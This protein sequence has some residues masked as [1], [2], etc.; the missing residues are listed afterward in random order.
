LLARREPAPEILNP[1]ANLRKEMQLFLR[2]NQYPR[3]RLSVTCR[4]AVSLGCLSIT[5]NRSSHTDGIP[6]R[7]WT[8]HGWIGSER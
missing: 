5:P 4:L 2:R 8:A 3:T 7:V 6:A 1:R